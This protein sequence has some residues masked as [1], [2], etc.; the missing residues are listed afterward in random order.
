MSI[1]DQ[2][3]N[4]EFRHPTTGDANNSSSS[5]NRQSTGMKRLHPASNAVITNFS[6]TYGT[7]TVNSGVMSVPSASATQFILPG[8]STRPSVKKN[9]FSIEYSCFVLLHRIQQ[10]LEIIQ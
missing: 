6:T 4:R 8:F 7:S 3:T 10:I 5:N 2:V 9:E 1:V